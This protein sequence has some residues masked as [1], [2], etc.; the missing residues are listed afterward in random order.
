MERILYFYFLLLK[1]YFIAEVYVDFSSWA[2]SILM[3]FH[4]QIIYITNIFLL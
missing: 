3:K 1:M 4:H 2:L